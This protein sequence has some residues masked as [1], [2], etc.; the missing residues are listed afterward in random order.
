MIRHTS[1]KVINTMQSSEYHLGNNK[2]TDKMRE[3]KHYEKKKERHVYR[4]Q[5]YK[6]HIKEMNVN[7]EK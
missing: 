6:Y 4:T 2:D 3:G 5:T 7:L 1:F